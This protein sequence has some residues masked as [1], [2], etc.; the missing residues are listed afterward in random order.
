[1]EHHFILGVKYSNI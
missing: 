1:M